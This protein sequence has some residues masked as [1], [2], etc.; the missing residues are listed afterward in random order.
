[1]DLTILC[2]YSAVEGLK[3]YPRLRYIWFGSTEKLKKKLIKLLKIK[4][5]LVLFLSGK[6]TSLL[7]LSSY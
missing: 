3:P 2:L 6:E 5:V 1:M 7:S 4:R